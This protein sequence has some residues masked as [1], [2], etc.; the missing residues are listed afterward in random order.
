M[1]LQFYQSTLTQSPLPEHRTEDII[2]AQGT[3]ITLKYINVTI[4][5]LLWTSQ[6][7]TLASSGS[8]L[9]RFHGI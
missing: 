3:K 4:N 9:V 2:Y 6:E 7:Q 5:S 1:S 8:C